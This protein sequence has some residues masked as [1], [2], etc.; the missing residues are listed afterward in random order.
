MAHIASKTCTLRTFMI[1]L[2]DEEV[3]VRSVPRNSSERPR[4]RLR[5]SGADERFPTNPPVTAGCPPIDG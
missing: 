3:A 5:E 4:V 1:S 2:R